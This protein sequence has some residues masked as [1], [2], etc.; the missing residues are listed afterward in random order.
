MLSLTYSVPRGLFGKITLA[1]GVALSVGGFFGCAAGIRPADTGEGG[2]NPISGIGGTGGLGGSPFGFG[3]SQG[4]GGELINPDAASCQEFAVMFK[5]KTPTVM[6]LVDRSTSMYPCLGSSDMSTFCADHANTSWDKVRVSMLQVVKSLQKDV[7]FGFATYNG[8][9]G[10]TCPV[11]NKVPPALDNYMAIS[12]LFDAQVWPSNQK[13]DKWETPTALALARVGA[14][15]MADTSAEGDKYILLSTDGAPDYCDDVIPACAIDDVIGKMQGL[16]AAGI[17]TIVF[18]LQSKV[19][20]LP[21]TTLQAFANAGAGEDT[22]APTPTGQDITAFWDQCNGN[23]PNWKSGIVAKFPECANAANFND[24]RG[25]TIGTYATVKG[26]SKPYLPDA[27]NQAQLLQQLS[28]A[29][30]GVKSCTFD[31]GGHVMVNTQR[32]NEAVIKIDGAVI[33]LDPNNNNGWNMSTP[34]QLELH[35]PA[36]DTWRAPAATDIHFGFPCDIIVG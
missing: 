21:A 32:L 28:S 30:A 22:L 26:P 33:P 20:D 4:L 2:H 19:N 10:G 34:T 35:G 11:L 15:L 9:K 3:G 23:V 1:A 14:D 31:L 8:I 6:I 13:N 27:A 17:T 16:K 18:G 5:P 36:C 24:C 7:R 12:D 29:L 25:K